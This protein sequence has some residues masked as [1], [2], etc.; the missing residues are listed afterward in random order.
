MNGILTERL[1][2]TFVGPTDATVLDGVDLSIEQGEW[3]A[4]LGRSGSGKSTLL[5]LLAGL[6]EPTSGRVI[7]ED[8]DLAAM[9][10]RER[11]LFRR[12]RFGIVFQA[13]QL[14][15]TLTAFENVLL[16]FDLDGRADRTAKS[17]VGD[18][19]DSV[20]LSARSHAFPETL[21]GGEQQRVALARALVH[22]PS[23]LLLDEPTG[24]LD[25][26]NAAG[27][28]DLVQSLLED[29][30]ARSGTIAV[31]ATHARSAASRCDRVLTL[32]SG[33]LVGAPTSDLSPS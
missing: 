1:T 27:V 3:V 21:S 20:G 16:P 11:T 7:V 28:M 14:V 6:D 18:M 31:M 13:F 4:L 26:E 15:P 8:R 32:S 23:V 33:R 25:A 5:H 24:N 19:L 29:G 10:D 2:K 9:S 17:A 22:R 30:G 12:R